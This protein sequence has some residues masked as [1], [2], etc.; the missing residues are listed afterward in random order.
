[1]LGLS[2]GRPKYCVTIGSQTLS[3][4][5]RSRSWRGRP[6]YRCLVSQIPHGAVKASPIEPNVIDRPALEER[7][8]ALVGTPRGFRIG[9]WAVARDLPRSV[10]LLLPDWSV[11]M[12]VLS[13]ERLP[14]RW[15][16]QDALIRWRLGQDQRLPLV[17]AKIVWQT[18]PAS[19]AAEP[20]YQVVVVSIQE[21]ILAEYESLCE[22]TGLIPREVG[23]TSLHLFNLWLRAS[24]THKT[25]LEDLVWIS[26]SDGG[27]TCLVIHRGRP[28][29]IRNKPAIVA[30]ST[31][32]N[33]TDSELSMR[34]VHEIQASIL[35]CRE[36]YPELTLRRLVVAAA[37]EWA[38]LAGTLEHELN[39]TVDRLN[40]DHLAPLGWSQHGGN[41]SS[42]TLPTVAG[43]AA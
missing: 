36:S 2:G 26:C 5:E 33:G 35:S 24:G 8:R 40:W 13:L 1:M 34:I 16:E 11:R 29:F 14:R 32:R 27:F 6:R 20:S 7:L 18:F 43:M 25:F 3:W 4:G 42:T 23:V 15:E 38:H 30:S 10:T 28:V 9:G 37:D 19:C 39:M 17:G 12:T 22:S 31:H 21:N 41:S